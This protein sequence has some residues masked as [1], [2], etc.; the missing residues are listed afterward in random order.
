MIN[1]E[2]STQRLEH[3]IYDIIHLY[4]Q[5][6][7]FFKL[8]RLKQT[9][10]LFHEYIESNTYN[11]VSMFKHYFSKNKNIFEKTFIDIGCGFPLI[12]LV[13]HHLGFHSVYGIENNKLLCQFLAN[14]RC[15][16]YNENLLDTDYVNYDCLYSYSPI[17]DVSMMKMGIEN[18]IKT[19]KKN[20][21]FYFLPAFSGEYESL[22]QMGFKKVTKSD[23]LFYYQKL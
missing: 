13:A 20:A 3:L 12:P 7:Y 5:S 22:T 17:K 9:N 21:Y 19:M 2:L 18:I 4:K 15:I 23:N 16:V 8:P 10:D 1:I 11:I 14:L 6:H